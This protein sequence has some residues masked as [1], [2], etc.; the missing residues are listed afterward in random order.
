MWLLLEA[1]SIHTPDFGLWI[2]LDFENQIYYFL[3]FLFFHWSENHINLV[4]TRHIAFS[5]DSSKHILLPLI[6]SRISSRS[7]EKQ[8]KSSFH[9]HYHACKDKWHFHFKFPIYCLLMPYGNCQLL[10]CGEKINKSVFEHLVRT[11]TDFTGSHC[12]T[13]MHLDNDFKTYWYSTH[14]WYNPELVAVELSLMLF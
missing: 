1:R 12:L 14:S 7:W 2:F 8:H 3:L 4:F 13:L 5:E 6:L 11:I 9:C 10:W